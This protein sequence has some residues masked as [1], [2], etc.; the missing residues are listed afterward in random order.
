RCRQ[1]TWPNAIHEGRPEGICCWSDLAFEEMMVGH[2]AD[3][4]GHKHRFRFES[5]SLRGRTK[6][7]AMRATKKNG[8]FRTK[9]QAA[10]HAVCARLRK[11][12]SAVPGQGVGRLP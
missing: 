6:S 10:C 1:R 7:S 9:L 4:R 2:C 11:R 5:S 8:A 12:P 3:Q